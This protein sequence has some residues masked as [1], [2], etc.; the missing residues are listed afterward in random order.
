M[1]VS[2][3]LNLSQIAMIIIKEAKQLEMKSF[4]LFSNGD[5]PN[6]PA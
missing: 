5:E 2:K 3:V 1:D 6:H 4:E